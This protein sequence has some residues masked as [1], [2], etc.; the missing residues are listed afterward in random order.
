MNWSEN[1]LCLALELYL[2]K[3]GNAWIRKIS[4]KT[5]EVIVLS[6]ILRNLDSAPEEKNDSFRSV[7][8]V[9]LK[10]ANFESVDPNYHSGAMR[11][12]SAGDRQIWIQFADDYGKLASTCKQIIIE[13][14]KGDLTQEVQDYYSAIGENDSE[15]K[16]NFSS[17]LSGV[18]EE[19]KKYIAQTNDSGI[20][21][22]AEEILT[23]IENQSDKGGTWKIHA[24]VNQIPI[25]EDDRKK[26]GDVQ[27][28]EKI[29]VHVRR[30][31]EELINNNLLT[32]MDIDNLESAEWCKSTFHINHAVL[33]SVD[34]QSNIIDQLRDKRGYVRYYLKTISIGGKDYALCKEWYERQRKY[35]DSWLNSFHKSDI[36]DPLL[37]F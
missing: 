8:S 10:L 29:G 17:Y 24:G 2:R 18:A 9:R 6:H 14:Y 22:K 33:R 3:G 28:D 34:I 25:R 15:L 19:L 37:N 21:K 35:F 30:S 36:D 1:E 13:H 16:N 4:N 11:N 7:N 27:T 23:T 5:E 20:K 31:F 12:V 32:K 26:R